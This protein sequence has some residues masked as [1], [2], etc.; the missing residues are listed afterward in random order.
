[1]R[2]WSEFRPETEGGLLPFE[3]VMAMMSTALFRNRMN[4][5]YVFSMASCPA[6][7]T[8]SH[9]VQ[10][11]SSSSASDG[12]RHDEFQELTETIGSRRP[13]SRTVEVQGGRVE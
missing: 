9:S 3:A 7:S 4:G 12:V 11:T 10:L 13:G 8:G 1:L 2:S 6:P 5:H